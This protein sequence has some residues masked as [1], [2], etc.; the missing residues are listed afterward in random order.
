[1]AENNQELMK[2]REEAD[3]LGIDYSM[4]IGASSLA[5]KIAR[6]EKEKEKAK[7]APPKKLSDIQV[8]KL[9][10]TSLSKV[11]IMNL[12]RENASATT[13]FSGVH[14]MKIDLARVI[15]L[16]M[17]IALE[18]ALIQ[19]VERRKMMI[20]E[21]VLDP[22]SKKPTGNFKMVEAPMYAVSRL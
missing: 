7:K 10:A 17:D 16:N 3:N 13:V 2:L 18:E 5:K 14:N 21:P 8:R 6:A 22:V 15:P 12:D 1:M 11:R 4:N 20:A 19:D 9:K